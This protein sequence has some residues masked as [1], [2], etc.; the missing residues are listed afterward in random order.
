[1]PNG[2]NFEEEANLTNEQLAGELAKLTPLT[3]EQLDKLLPKKV[4]KKRLQQVIDIV[5]SSA[6]Q[7]RKLASL[8]A[9][10]S[11]LGGVVLKVLT[12]YLKPM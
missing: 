5:N 4:D 10:F 8:T 1:M 12:K 11:D 2:Y 3:A 7:N 9:N 6:S